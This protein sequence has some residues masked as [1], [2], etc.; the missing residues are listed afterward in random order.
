LLHSVIIV[1]AF[2]DCHIGLVKSTY[3]KQMSR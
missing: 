1:V 3:I 2:T